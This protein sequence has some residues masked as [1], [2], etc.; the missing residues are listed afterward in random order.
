MITI[1]QDGCE[2]LLILI[3]EVRKEIMKLEKQ[4]GFGITLNN[5]AFFKKIILLY[6][7]YHHRILKL[8]SKL[9]HSQK[10][11]IVMAGHL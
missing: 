7:I 9:L 8:P 4:K 5:E 6:F 11:F 2:K 3:I 1:S 10:S